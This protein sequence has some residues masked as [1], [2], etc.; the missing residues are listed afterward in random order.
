[1]AADRWL[2]FL[3]FLLGP[4]ELKYMTRLPYQARVISQFGQG[5]FTIFYYF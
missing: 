3:A 4:I 5:F 1:M 2:C